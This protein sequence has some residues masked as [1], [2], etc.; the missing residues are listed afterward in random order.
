M[1]RQVA[2]GE[3]QPPEANAFSISLL[4]FSLLLLSSVVFSSLL[5]VCPVTTAKGG[6]TGRRRR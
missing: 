6:K 3:E 5:L 1:Q 4:T 2:G